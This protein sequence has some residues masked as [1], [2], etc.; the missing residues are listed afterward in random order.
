[1][2]AWQRYARILSSRSFSIDRNDTLT[3]A[4]VDIILR[5]PTAETLSEASFY[6]NHRLHFC[7]D[8]APRA[9]LSPVSGS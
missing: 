4:V 2:R 6:R 9:R 5:S 7:G 1:M 8:P 3:P